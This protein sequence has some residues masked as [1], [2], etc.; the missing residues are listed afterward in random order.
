MVK[1]LDDV[2]DEHNNR[3]YQ[4]K[5]A[6]ELKMGSTIMIY[7]NLCVFATQRLCVKLS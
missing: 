6:E 4:R 7:K 5:D 1:D 3:G 2:H